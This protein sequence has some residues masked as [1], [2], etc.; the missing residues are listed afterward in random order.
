MTTRLELFRE[1][2]RC[3]GHVV[4]HPITLTLG[5]IG[6]FTTALTA[7]LMAAV[8]SLAAVAAAAVLA[9]QW[10]P[11]RRLVTRAVEATE[12]SRRAALR[13]ARLEEAR[14]S[15]R[16]DLVEL[17]CL[18]EEIHRNDATATAE[19]EQV[20]DA[21]VERAVRSERLSTAVAPAAA[22]CLPAIE[23]GDRSAALH[24]ELMQRRA[25]HHDQCMR[26]ARALDRELDAILELVRLVAQRTACPTDL[27][28]EADDLIERRLWEMDLRDEALARV[29]RTLTCE[30][31]PAA[32]E[33]DFG[34]AD[35]DAAGTRHRG[36]CLSGAGQRIAAPR[37]HAL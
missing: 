31:L 37:L 26:R 32:R 16:G 14:S 7:G 3:Y 21:F 18:I 22:I 36:E 33:P 5:L 10:R 8:A 11:I 6:F 13:E 28:D 19:V 23:P 17:A 35:D 25:A 12:R 29:D 9:V 4:R 2:R 30:E 27:D 20:V 1:R 24:R 15:R 34:P